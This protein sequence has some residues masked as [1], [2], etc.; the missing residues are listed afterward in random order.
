MTRPFD[1]LLNQTLRLEYVTGDI[2][3]F[4]EISD[5]GWRN[6]PYMV[7]SYQK[8]G[9]CRFSYKEN[10]PKTVN[11]NELIVI[12]AGV[13]HRTRSLVKTSA[14]YWI[15]INYFVMND[16]D[17]FS[18]VE[19]PSV[20]GGKIASRIGEIIKNWI[21]FI[22]QVPPD[23]IIRINAQKNKIGFEILGELSSLIKLF[24]E[25]QS[26]L[27][28][29]HQIQPSLNRIHH[30]FVN[31]TGRDELAECCHL[32]ASQFHRVFALAMGISPMEYVRN[33][34]IRRAQQLL[35]TTDL[36]VGEITRLAGYQDP[37]I[38]SRYFKHKCGLSP[39]HYRRNIKSSLYK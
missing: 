17:L 35:I 36:T 18:F 13:T 11:A 38:F 29:I 26:K 4:H 3:R 21:I 8:K 30:D 32:S 12:P 22:H 7:L 6:L 10:P 31:L 1:N 2:T 20:I 39:E 34:R 23:D 9:S 15:H 27:K 14:Y 37:F 5:T 16:I 28:Y 19:I 25:N 24:P 33:L